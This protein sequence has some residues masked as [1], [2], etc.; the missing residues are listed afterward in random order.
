M[1]RNRENFKKEISEVLNRHS[2]EGIADIPDFL[3]AEMVTAFVEQVLPFIKD[4]DKWFGFNTNLVLSCEESPR[5]LDK[6][7]L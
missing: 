5:K 7:V 2:A 6:D 4:R 1:I 3:L